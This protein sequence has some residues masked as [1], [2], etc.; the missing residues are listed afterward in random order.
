LETFDREL[1][2]IFGT[3]RRM[4]VCRSDMEDLLQDVFVVLHTNWPTLDTTR[5]LRPWLFG[6]AFRVV[7]TRRRQRARELPSD[8]LDPIDT[9]DTPEGQVQGLETVAFLKAALERVPVERRSVVIMHDLDGVDIVDIAR[10]LSITKFG[11]YSRL[12]KGR[13]EL[14]SAVRVLWKEG[15]PR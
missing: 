3:L 9:A 10:Q 2:Y 5:T 11:V 12:Y 13:K 1:D 6:V 7:Q 14:S 8:A 15:M 4:G